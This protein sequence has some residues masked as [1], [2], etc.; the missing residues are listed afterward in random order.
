VAAWPARTWWWPA[1]AARHLAEALGTPTVGLFWCGNMIK[2]AP[3][4]RAANRMLIGWTVR[5]PV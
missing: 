3:F 1:T 5:C 4:G 2:A